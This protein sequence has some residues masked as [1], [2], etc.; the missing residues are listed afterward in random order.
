MYTEEEKKYRYSRYFDLWFGAF[1]YSAG[2]AVLWSYFKHIPMTKESWYTYLFP[3]THTSSYWYLTAYTPLFFLVP[4]LNKW[5]RALKKRELTILV[6]TLITFFSFIN[7]VYDSFSLHDGY[8]FLW[9]M[10]LYLVG[11]WIKKCDIPSRVRGWSAFLFAVLCVAASWVWYM[12]SPWR[13]E[14]AIKYNCPTILFYAIAL[15]VLLSKFKPKAWLRSVIKFLT[16]AVFGVYLIHEHP[17][18]RSNFATWF[19]YLTKHRLLYTIPLLL[20]TVFVVFTTCI[21][22]E[23]ARLFLYGFIKSKILMINNTKRSSGKL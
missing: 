15:V 18:I 10:I 6:I 5:I 19:E 3:V 20:V 14:L 16:P 2:I 13:P 23:K 22:I 21:L 11:A 1:F 12:Y 4:W 8:S 9:L 7:L 17:C